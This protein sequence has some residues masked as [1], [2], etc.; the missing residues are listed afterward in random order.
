MKENAMSRAL[1][2]SLVAVFCL[3]RAAAA[4]SPAAPIPGFENPQ[5]LERVM[6]GE[7]VKEEKISTAVEVQTIMRAFFNKVSPDAYVGLATDHPKYVELFPDLIKEA[8]TTKVNADHTEWDYW[9]DIL[10]TMGI[11]QTHVYPEGHQIYRKAPDAASEA[12][13]LH[14][15]TNYQDYIKSA[16]QTTRLIPYKTGMLVHDDIHLVMKKE[17][18]HT[19]MIKE[20]IAKQFERYISTFREHLQGSY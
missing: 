15:I 8:K 11:F 18:S 2:L 19:A 3:A 7:I 17:S 4:A 16:T 5:I 6:G 20:Q 9:M 1:C 10:Y 12:T 14:N 13:L